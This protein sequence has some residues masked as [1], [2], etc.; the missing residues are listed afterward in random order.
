MALPLPLGLD[1]PT[2][3]G[4]HLRRLNAD[5]AAPFHAAVTTPAIGRMLFMFP[6]DWG[7]ADARAFMAEHG[8]RDHPP[9]RLA[10]AAGDGSFLG[11]VGL[12]GSPADEV[13]FFLTPQ[14][15]GL[16]VMQVALAGFIDLLRAQF[17][18]DG[19]RA[20]VYHDNPASINLLRKLGFTQTGCATGRCSAQRSGA[21]MLHHFALSFRK[22]P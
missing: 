19:L 4:L 14:A 7:L 10:I 1:H 8:P 13:S 9:L 3:A 22:C 21:E 2:L 11:N 5:D 15:Q 20:R 16:G 12:V 6:A 17:A 18:P